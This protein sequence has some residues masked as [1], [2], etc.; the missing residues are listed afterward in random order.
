MHLDPR[1]E[2]GFIPGT[3]TTDNGIVLND[4]C[5]RYDLVLLFDKRDLTFLGYPEI[6]FGNW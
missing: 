5:R 2:K 6:V 4:K 1:D 3:K